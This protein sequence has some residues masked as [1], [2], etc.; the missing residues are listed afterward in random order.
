MRRFR[1]IQLMLL[2]TTFVYWGCRKTYNPPVLNASQYFISV[3]GFIN[4]GVNT[5]TRFSITRSQN[6]TDTVTG[7]PEPG[8]TV[9]IVGSDGSVYPLADSSFTGTYISD[10]LTLDTSKQF[11]LTIAT[12]EGNKYESDEVHA[13]PT[14]PIDDTLQWTIAFDPSANTGAVAFY[15]NTHDPTNNTRFYRWTYTETWEHDAQYKAFLLVENKK[16]V[17]DGDSV[18]HGWYCFND[19]GPNTILLGNSSGLTSDRIDRQ[20]ITK[21][22]QN[23]PKTDIAYSILVKQYALDAAGYDYWTLVQKNVQA[24][25]GLFDSQPVQILGN[26]HN[27]TEP[28]VIVYGYISACTETTTRTFI[29]YD[30]LPGWKSPRPAACP[31][32]PYVPTGLFYDYEYSDP[33]FTIYVYGQDVTGAA[34]QIL[35]LKSCLDC[36][37]QGGGT[38]ITPSYWK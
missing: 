28:D 15:L 5:Q 24:L 4:T 17:Y 25:G 12:P 38:K 18:K 13:K 37:Y 1:I 30:E 35:T 20:L 3:D 33:N 23:D 31:M 7:I 9:S 11:K 26:I 36:T 2:L 6:L 21:L 27:L 10:A 32:I 34:A 29:K 14:P 22:Y 8:A 19:A 16:I